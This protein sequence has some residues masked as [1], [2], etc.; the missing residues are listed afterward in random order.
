MP[1]IE[2]RPF[3][4]FSL[5]TIDPICIAGNTTF[6]VIRVQGAIAVWLTGADQAL[7]TIYG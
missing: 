5:Q 1:T 6:N 4:T 2:T 7:E 3:L